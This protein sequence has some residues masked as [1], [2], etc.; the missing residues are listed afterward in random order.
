[1]TNAQLFKIMAPNGFIINI[2]EN[3]LIQILDLD[4][5]LLMKMI[6]LVNNVKEIM[7]TQRI[8][9]IALKMPFILKLSIIVS[10]KIYLF[11][12]NYLFLII[13]F[14]KYVIKS[15]L[16]VRKKSFAL[17]AKLIIQMFLIALVVIKLNILQHRLIVK[18]K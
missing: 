2:P 9:V 8:I 1:M 15:V 5:K 12:F 18:V 6:Y 14:K 7:Q 3:V 17:N 11:F 4:V 10:V 16:N 13:F